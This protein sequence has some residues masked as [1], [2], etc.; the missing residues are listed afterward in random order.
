[1]CTV[2]QGSFPGGRPHPTVLL[3][4]RTGYVY[5]A[6]SKQ[7]MQTIM[8]NQNNFVIQQKHTQCF[9]SSNN[10]NAYRL[11]MSKINFNNTGIPLPKNVLQKMENFFNTHLS[12]V[13]IH[14]DGGQAE[15]IGAL[16]FTTG[17]NI[18]FA[19][20]RYNPYTPQGLK[21]LGH[22]LAHV[23]QQKQGRVNNKYGEGVVVVHSPGLE[24]EAERMGLSVSY[25]F[26]HDFPDPFSSPGSVKNIVLQR[27]M[28]K[29][30]EER[31]RGLYDMAIGEINSG[32]PM[33]IKSGTIA[34]IKLGALNDITSI[35]SDYSYKIEPLE[36]YFPI[37][38]GTFDRTTNNRIPEAKGKLWV[39][40]LIN[41]GMGLADDW[42]AEQMKNLQSDDIIAEDAKQGYSLKKYILDHY[43]G[44]FQK[45]IEIFKIIE[46]KKPLTIDRG[47]IIQDL[48]EIYQWMIKDFKIDF[49]LGKK[50]PTVGI[51][52]NNCAKKYISM[53][54][55]EWILNNPDIL[56]NPWL[57]DESGF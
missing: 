46:N 18:Y 24:A 15:T 25:K 26:K 28:K 23:L 55:I 40:A 53:V 48:R 1:M 6:D 44:K 35:M 29:N 30:P 47:E 41:S 8:S 33:K 11:D 43:T 51:H 56:N 52:F 5:A 38:F 7:V 37:N 3:N 2:I 17:N 54:K 39:L 50:Y 32:D 31:E 12:D 16:A 19:K 34:L 9:N 10:C 14:A 45:D 4:Q 57:A 42:L 20:G 36:E 49:D 27:A 21:L 22:E 13:K